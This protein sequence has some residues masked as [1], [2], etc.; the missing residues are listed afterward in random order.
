MR[1]VVTGMGCV[2]AIG[3]S[4]D[5][6]WDSALAG[7]GG[8]EA[9]AF[10]VDGGNICVSA[11]VA[12][13]KAD[14]MPMLMTRFGRKPI[15][16]VDRF[17]NL[18][19]AA[20][21]E[22]LDDA[23]LDAGDVRLERASIVY[24]ACSGGLV[25]IE[26]AYQRMFLAGAANPH[27]LTVPRLMASAPAS[28][29][30]I[31]FGVQ[32]LCLTVATACASSAHA[33]AEGMHL[34]RS[35]RAETVIVGGTDASLTYGA[36]QSWDA[37]QATSPA[38]CRPFSRGRDGTILGEGA[39]TLILE[40]E[41]SA[42]QR[43]APVHCILAGAG[44]SSDASHMTQPN[45]ASAAA[46]VRAAHADAGLPLDTAL[47]ISAHGTG[48]MLNDKTETTVLRDVYGAH[49]AGN[50]VIATK[51]A[52]GH[53]LGATGAMEFILAIKAL[54]QGIAPPILNYIEADPDCHLPLV[55]EPEQMAYRAVVSTS[56]AFG[57]LNS[58]LIANL[59]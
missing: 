49:L 54:V 4:V 17:A 51:S 59:P 56:F 20:T 36:M 12:A 48:T 41:A 30:S 34:I 7:R 23:G 24:G 32:G 28:H 18:A 58:V 43:G 19:A 47:L 35:G 27:P 14:P 52:H 16:A 1:V 29:L 13:L 33:I 6:A 21:M 15:L 50:R 42:R 2:S 25:S 26:G 40:S 37:L 53:M 8:A 46:A 55:L 3:G 39:A 45:A 31:L 44:A 38:A 9:T 5:S 11:R 22:A 57:G 10:T